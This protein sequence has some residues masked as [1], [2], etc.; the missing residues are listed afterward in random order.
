[1]DEEQ[2][3]RL[4]KIADQISVLE[5]EVQILIRRLDEIENQKNQKN[6]S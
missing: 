5:I 2:K 6:E 1:M 3:R 4:D